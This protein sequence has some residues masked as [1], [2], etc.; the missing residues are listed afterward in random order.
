MNRTDK[1]ERIVQLPFRDWRLARRAMISSRN[2][3]EVVLSGSD[4]D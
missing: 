2:S 1:I 4:G 3:R